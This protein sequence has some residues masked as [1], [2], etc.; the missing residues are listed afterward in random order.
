MSKSM[1]RGSK[2]VI[3]AAALVLAGVAQAEVS[4]YGLVDLS[5]GKNEFL[6]PGNKADF[7]S[8]G[9]LD[10]SQ[11]NSVTKLGVRVSNEVAPGLKANANF[12]TAGI[13][14]KGEVGSAAGTP[15]FNRQAWAG[16]SGTF[17]EVRL[18]K[19]DGV[20]FQ[21]LIGFDFNGF[22]NGASAFAYTGVAGYLGAGGRQDRSLQ[23]ISPVLGDVKVQLGFQPE[24]N[25]V[26]AKSNYGL[27]VTYAK[28]PIAAAVAFETKRTVTG[29]DAVGVSASYD[30]TVVK[31]VANY[32]DRGLN[33]KGVG[34]GVVAPVAGFNVGANY[35]RNSDTKDSALELFVNREIFKSTVAY[36]DVGRIKVDATNTTSTNYAVGVIYAF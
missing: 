19:Q 17:G 35:G 13:T 14:S 11:G 5:Y 23:Y 26:G 3:G 31:V 34:L 18:G 10:S 9:D 25:V 24:G 30:F 12:E 33:Q 28:G 20:A 32:A 2:V 4:L 29:E 15:F 21:T 36:V 8:G 7:H 22:S 1:Y 27:G 16:V 6:E